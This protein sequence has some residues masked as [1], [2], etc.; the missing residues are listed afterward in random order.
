MDM[1]RATIDRVE[2]PTA[3]LAMIGDR[4]FDEAAF[5][6]ERKIASS[7]RRKSASSSRRTRF[8]RFAF[9]PL[10]AKLLEMDVVSGRAMTRSDPIPGKLQAYLLGVVDFESAML[11]QRRLHYDVTGNRDRAALIVCEHPPMITVG[12]HGSHRHMPLDDRGWPVRWVPRGGGCWLHTA[13]QIAFYPILPLDRLGLLIPD[14]LERLGL[15]LGRVLGDFSV[16]HRLNVTD[17]GVCVGQRPVGALGIGVRE[18]VTMFGGCFNICP[19]LEL[20]RGIRCH[21]AATEPM[22][23]LERERRGP[24]RPSLVRERLVDHFADVFGFSQVL[25]FSDHVL[26]NRRQPDRQVATA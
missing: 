16:H 2:S 26:L 10:A 11:L 4:F 3:N 19:D 1:I 24:V 14:Y 7:L 25:P 18:Q 9:L 23:S 13:G 5:I 12:R 17:A 21:P 20:F 6:A 8:C 15:V 22:S